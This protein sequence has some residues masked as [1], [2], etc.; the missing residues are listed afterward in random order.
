MEKGEEQNMELEF[1]RDHIHCY[2][3]VLDTT[4]CQEETM[5][6]IVP[7][8]CPDI[9]RVVD[10]C[11]QA[12]LTGKLIRDG[13][14]SV[15]G[16]IRAVILYQPEG[17][18][19]GLRRMELSLPFTCQA[20]ASGLTDA[21]TVLASPRLR[22]AEA[23][24]LNPRKVL[25]R[26]ELAVDIMACQ[27]QEQAVCGSVV[28]P[29]A[30]SVCQMSSQQESY[31]LFAV[32]ERPFTFSEQIRLPGEAVQMLAC[33]ATPVC[34]ESKLIG[35]KLIFKGSVDVQM[36][37]QDSGGA[38]SSHREAL[39]FSQVMEVP[40]AGEEGD[41]QV[42]VEL[43]DLTYESMGDGDQSVD[44]N[45]DLLAQ[46]RVWSRRPITV[47]QDL[48]ST[49]W[50]TEVQMGQQPVRQLVEQSV[51]PQSVRELV[52]TG[53]MIRSV[54]DSWLTMG[55]VS[56]SREGEQLL[57]TARPRVSILC[58]DEA[59]QPQMVQKEL[60]VICRL[61]CPEGAV[62]SCRCLCSGEVFAAPVAG[63]LEVRFTVEFHCMA[64]LERKI[65]AVTGGRLG[66]ERTRGGEGRPSIVL[67]LAAPGEALWDIAKAY[68]T[69]MEEIRQ[70]NELEEGALPG[71]T[72][73]LIPRA[74]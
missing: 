51:R 8:A 35:T 47:L 53:T 24:V 1:E 56:R 49:G 11:G 60:E 20:E 28:D 34:G 41:C 10:C 5:E 68:G 50:N 36:L 12:F 61:D 29:E 27:P 63:G 66:E 62:C 64:L 9:Q 23:R 18:G 37:L 69:T 39:T 42:V 25:L 70:A 13:L 30:H 74:R 55:E 4:L 38:L 73:L 45:L 43:N 16:V 71:N 54:V 46:A 2:E 58:L 44:V 3:T 21:G 48:Y 7:D 31:Q 59:D 17:E 40:G 52:E 14:A 33:R 15:S 6:S 72:M 22:W 67:R 19:A 32:Q 65:P 26:V 57:L